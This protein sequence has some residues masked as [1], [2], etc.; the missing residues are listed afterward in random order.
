[1]TTGRRG[2]PGWVSPAHATLL[3]QLDP[4]GM[5]MADLGRSKL[6]VPP[7]EGIVRRRQAR[8]LRREPK[9]GLAERIGPQRM[10]ALRDALEQDWGEVAGRGGQRRPTL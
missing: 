9:A 2:E 8:E 3:S 10:P 1:M 6:V 5:P 7:P 4:G